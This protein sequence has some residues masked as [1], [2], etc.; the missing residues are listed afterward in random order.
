MQ[1]SSGLDLSRLLKT[2][3][4][5]LSIVVITIGSRRWLIMIGIVTSKIDVQF[6]QIPSMRWNPKVGELT[7]CLRAS[8]KWEAQRVVRLS[9]WV[10]WLLLRVHGLSLLRWVNCWVH[11]KGL[12]LSHGGG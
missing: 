7:H 5:W 1:G 6:F 2:H 11:S 3:S 9:L 8:T 12:L 4:S 10:V